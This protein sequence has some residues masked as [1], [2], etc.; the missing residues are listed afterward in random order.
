MTIDNMVKQT[1]EELSKEIGF[2]Y[3]T[4]KALYDIDYKLY[5]NSDYKYDKITSTNKALEAV[6][7]YA[8]DFISRGN[9]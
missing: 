1:L 7:K 9:K 8:K 2:E 4:L 6:T 5:K 3:S